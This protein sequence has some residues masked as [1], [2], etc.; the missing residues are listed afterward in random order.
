M[1][2]GTLSAENEVVR[3]AETFKLVEG[4]IPHTARWRGAGELRG[5]GDPMHACKP[6]TGTWEVFT[7]PRRSYRGRKGKEVSEA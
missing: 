6:T 3:S 7:L 1:R 2:A 5:V 4:N